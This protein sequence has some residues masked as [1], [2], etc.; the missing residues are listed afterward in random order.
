MMTWVGLTNRVPYFF[1]VFFQ[2]CRKIVCRLDITFIFD[3]CPR[4]MARVKYECVSTDLRHILLQ[5]AKCSVTENLWR[6]LITP[7]LVP[8]DVVVETAELTLQHKDSHADCLITPHFD[9]PKRLQWWY[10]KQ[11]RSSCLFYFIVIIKTF[12]GLGLTA[13]KTRQSGHMMQ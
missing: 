11:E 3:T 8:G 4:S 9:S 7:P 6:P 13:S 1:S 2:N 5:N 12:K 10:P